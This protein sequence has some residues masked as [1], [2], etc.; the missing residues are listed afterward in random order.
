MRWRLQLECIHVVGEHGVAGDE[1]GQGHCSPLAELG[2]GGIERGRADLAVLQ[3]FPNEIDG[4][5]LLDCLEIALDC[6]RLDMQ[7]SPYDLSAQGLAPV[8]VE[9]PQGR[10]EYARC[11]R[12]L[13]ARAQALRPRLAEAYAEL[14][15]RMPE[16]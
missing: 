8:P 3:E 11:Q 1:V 10:E 5:L 12:Q 2:T 4:D 9:T 13:M 14:L 16:E 7:A 15:E 6:R